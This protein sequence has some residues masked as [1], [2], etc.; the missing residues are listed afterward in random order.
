MG[1]N[2]TSL[3][4]VHM[5]C[6]ANS[7]TKCVPFYLPSLCFEDCVQLPGVGHNGDIVGS[8]REWLAPILISSFMMPKSAH[9]PLGHGLDAAG[10]ELRISSRPFPFSTAHFVPPPLWCYNLSD[11]AAPTLPSPS[12]LVPACRLASGL[13]YR[14]TS[15]PI[16]ASFD[17]SQSPQAQDCAPPTSS[18]LCSAAVAL[19]LRPQV[20]HPHAE[21]APPCPSLL[22]LAA[23]PDRC[24]SG[25]SFSGLRAILRPNFFRSFSIVRRG[26]Y[27]LNLA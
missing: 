17:I 15:D 7:R 14:P 19:L 13:G 1:V 16:S 12:I 10:L 11:P 20:R 3:E 24:I 18:T 5:S 22:A 4:H 21:A 25:E 9:G 6:R 2:K 23:T 8:S 26:I 27:S